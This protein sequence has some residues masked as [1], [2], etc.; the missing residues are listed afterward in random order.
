MPPILPKFFVY[1]TL[2]L[3]WLL[4]L[5]LARPRPSKLDFF[6]G[7]LGVRSELFLLGFMI[8]E[9]E[10]KYEKSILHMV[11]VHAEG[12]ESNKISVMED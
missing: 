3:L 11:T 9:L 4:A 1:P 5:H 10:K 7:G 12:W 2:S 8:M 6:V